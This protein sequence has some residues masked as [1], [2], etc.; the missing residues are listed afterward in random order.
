MSC[1]LVRTRESAYDAYMHTSESACGA[2]MYIYI[3]FIVFFTFEHCLCLQFAH[4]NIF[5][6]L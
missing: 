6:H 4:V 5:H 3:Y 1:F 2:Y